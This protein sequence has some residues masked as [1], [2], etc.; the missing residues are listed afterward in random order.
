MLYLTII[1]GGFIAWLILVTLFTPAIPYHIE[2][3][4]DPASDHFIHVLESACNTTLKHGNTIGVFTNGTSFYPA[5]LDAIRTARE[6]VNMECY[7]FKRGEIGDQFIR[8]LAE[9]ARAGVRVTIV[10]DSIGSWGTY[11]ASGK[12]LRDAGCRVERYQ[13]VRWYSLAR[14]NNRTHRELLVIDGRVAFVGGA[15][16]ADWWWK[17]YR[18]RPIWRDMMARIEG[19]LV[20][21]I[22]GIVAE[23]WLECCGEILTGPETYKPHK[24]V[25][26]SPGLAVRS[27]PS[28]RATASRVLFQTLVESARERVLLTTPYFLPDRAFRRALRRTAERGVE[29]MVVVPGLDTDQRWVRLASRRMY[30][31]LLGSGVR[32]FEY[33]GGMIHTKSLVVDGLWGVVGTTNLDNRSFEHNDEINVAIRDAAVADRLATDFAHDLARSYEVP[34]DRWDA[35]PA[36]EKLIGTVAWI[37][38]RQQ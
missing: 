8:A 26:Q 25:G 21:D 27:S 11:R 10:M 35:R 19:P 5:M 3:P 1:G 28:D 6:T 22:Q 15:G 34:A 37:L 9:R 31:K 12:V 7:I 4:I 36:W 24:D 16:V 20:S 2:K 23:N 30:G 14:L 33:G 17:P 13:R 38:E 18:G 32:I 29:I